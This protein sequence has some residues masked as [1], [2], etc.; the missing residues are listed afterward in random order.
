[1]SPYPLYNFDFGVLAE[2]H[3]VGG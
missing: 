2:I 3:W 1:M